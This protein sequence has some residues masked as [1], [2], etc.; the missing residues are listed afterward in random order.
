MQEIQ[1]RPRAG[2]GQTTSP[3]NGKRPLTKRVCGRRVRPSLYPSP[4]RG[5]LF[6]VFCSPFSVLR[7][8]LAAPPNQPGALR[9]PVSMLM[10]GVAGAEGEG[11]E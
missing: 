2:D 1:E 3:A 9:A 6:S 7:G 4:R 8:G 10:D 5:A 11:K